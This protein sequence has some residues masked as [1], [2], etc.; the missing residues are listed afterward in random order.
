MNKQTFL[1]LIGAAHNG[2]LFLTAQAKDADHVKN[3]LL[4]YLRANHFE[5]VTYDD[6]LKT[7]FCLGWHSGPLVTAF[8]TADSQT[9]GSIYFSI[10]PADLWAI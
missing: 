2:L 10:E 5:A 9:Y 4:S 3:L 6:E 7:V 8:K 1:I